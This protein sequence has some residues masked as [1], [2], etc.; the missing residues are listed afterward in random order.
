MSMVVPFRDARYMTIA[1]S[2]AAGRR[3][4]PWPPLVRRATTAYIFE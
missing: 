2:L 3:Q 1:T 4:M